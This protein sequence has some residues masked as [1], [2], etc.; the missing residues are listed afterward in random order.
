MEGFKVDASPHAN[1]RKDDDPKRSLLTVL[2]SSL[3]ERELGSGIKI[4]NGRGRDV[5][6]MDK[7]VESGVGGRWSPCLSTST[8]RSMLASSGSSPFSLIESRCFT[9]RSNQISALVLSSWAA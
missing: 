2:W 8:S 6:E 3:L 1:L 5:L 7:W 4:P 9:G